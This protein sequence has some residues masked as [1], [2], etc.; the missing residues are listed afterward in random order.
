MI[1]SPVEKASPGTAAG[2]HRDTAVD[3]LR[4]TVIVLVVLLHAA[5]AYASF[6][7]YDPADYIHAT[8]PVV[9]SARWPAVD[10]PITFIDLFGMPLLF[11]IS[12]LFVV[13]ALERKGSGGFFRSR[14]MRLGAPFVAAAFVLSP[15][16]FWPG[17]LLSTR[18][19]SIPYWIRFFTTDGW[20]IGAPWFLW[21]LLSFDGIAALL[22]RLAAGFT[23]WLRR[24]AAPLILLAA[25]SAVFV[26]L[27]LFFSPYAWL[28]DLGPFDVEYVRLPLFFG[29]FLIGMALGAGGR[30]ADWPKR[31]GGWLAGGMAAFVAFLFLDSNSANLAMK[32]AAWLAYAAGCAGLSLGLFG[33]YR[34]FVHPRNRIIASLNANSFGIYIFHYPIGHWLQYALLSSPLPAPAKFGLVFA[35]AL[36]LSW[37]ISILFRSLWKRRPYRRM[38]ATGAVLRPGA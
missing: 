3:T 21:V 26:S 15:I 12:G 2:S 34:A 36:L 29:Y 38:E 19:S 22:H 24:S 23:A 35:G 6:S 7:Q 18:D 1:R 31:W 25:A 5:L 11:L 4:S 8:A 16:A 30:A 13:P 10:I 27:S 28:R 32:A 17:Y 37:G 14:L 20:M 9:D 33:A